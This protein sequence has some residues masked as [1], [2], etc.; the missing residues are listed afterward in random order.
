MR[1]YQDEITRLQDAATA[2]RRAAEQQLSVAH[3]QLAQL[4]QQ[5]QTWQQQA[6]HLQQQSQDLQ[7]QLEQQNCTC[8]A[9]QQ[10]LVQQEQEAA[11]A[12][13]KVERQLVTADAERLQLRDQLAAAQSEIAMLSPG[14]QQCQQQQQDHPGDFDELHAEATSNMDNWMQPEEL[15]QAAAMHAL[16][17]ELGMAN[18]EV[19]RLQHQLDVAREAQKQERELSGHEII[20]LQQ[21]LSEVSSRSSGA[22]AAAAAV[23]A[24]DVTAAV[25]VTSRAGGG[26]FGSDSTGSWHSV[27]DNPAFEQLEQQAAAQCGAGAAA[28]EADSEGLHEQQQLQYGQAGMSGVCD[29]AAKAAAASHENFR[30]LL[31]YK[32]KLQDQ[33]DTISS[34]QRQLK[35]QEQLLVTLQKRERRVRCVTV[36]TVFIENTT[37]VYHV[38]GFWL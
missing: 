5:E 35:Q 8:D 15:P 36:G 2:D 21:E 27:H 25:E 32:E 37:V 1:R 9:L 6:A 17:A 7:Q 10:Q 3:R 24:G 22:V 30:L 11:A 28:V 23:G 20:R 29:A 33:S 16:R 34:L 13:A 14:S 38:V 4:Q 26:R 31:R 19:A 12:Q 18:A